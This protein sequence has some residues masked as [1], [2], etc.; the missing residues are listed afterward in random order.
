RLKLFFKKG[1][2]FYAEYNI[3]LFFYLLFK[4][5]DTVCCIDLDTMLPAYYISLLRKKQRVYDAHE[6]FTQM[7][8][9]VQRPRVYKVWHYIERRF[10]PK[11]PTGY[12]VSESIAQEFKKLYGVEYAVIRNMPMLENIEIPV[13]KEKILLYQGA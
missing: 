12:T 3:R 11:F 5:F 8:E 7:K 9:I 6:Y 1:F 2:A 4:K 10:V 13:K